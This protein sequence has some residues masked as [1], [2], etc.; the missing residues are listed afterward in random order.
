MTGAEQLLEQGGENETQET[1]NV[2]EFPSSSLD[3]FSR[4]IES[5]LKAWHFPDAERVHFEEATRDI[6]IAG[7]RRGSR[8]KGMRAVTHAAFTIGLLEFCRKENRSHPGFV[9]LE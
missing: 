5:I 4:E 9:V 6:V 7:K 3:R 2:T 8:G 1:S